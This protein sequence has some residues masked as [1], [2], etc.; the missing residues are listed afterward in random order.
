MSTVQHT[1][2][3]KNVTMMGGFV[4]LFVSG[5]PVLAGPPPAPAYRLRSQ[6][7]SLGR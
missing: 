4:L 7:G 3:F 5:R 6:H 2:F 1:H